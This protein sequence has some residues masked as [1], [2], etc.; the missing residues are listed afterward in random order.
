[1]SISTQPSASASATVLGCAAKANE[2][3]GLNIQVVLRLYHF[4]SAE[5]RAHPKACNMGK[6]IIYKI[7]GKTISIF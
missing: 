6:Q 1:L 2:S 3:N 4:W 5:A 7:I